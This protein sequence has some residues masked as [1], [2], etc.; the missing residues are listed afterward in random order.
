ML[1]LNSAKG[2]SAWLDGE[3]VT[4]TEKTEVSL[5]AGLHNLTLV[6]DHGARTQAVRLE[7]EDSAASAGVR[8]V[9]GK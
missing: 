9:G 2:L 3:A 1:L 6:V 7:V 5:P 4:L 8:F